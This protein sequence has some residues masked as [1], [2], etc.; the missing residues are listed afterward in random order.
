V[1]G[2]IAESADIENGFS[3]HF[4][5]QID[6][7]SVL[8]RHSHFLFRLLEELDR[9]EWLLLLLCNNPWSFVLLGLLCRLGLGWF[10]QL[11]PVNFEVRVA[12]GPVFHVEVH[13]VTILALAS[14]QHLLVASHSFKYTRRRLL[15]LECLLYCSFQGS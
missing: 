14:T 7:F 10:L 3:F 15:I 1:I 8:A 2:D 11:E 13:V 6:E 4:P 9:G 12:N 5:F